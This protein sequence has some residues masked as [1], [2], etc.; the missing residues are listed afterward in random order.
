LTPPILAAAADGAG[1]DAYADRYR[2]L[3]GT[4]RSLGADLQVSVYMGELVAFDPL[5]PP[6]ASALTRLVPAGADRYRVQASGDEVLSNGATVE[7]TSPGPDGR[8][9]RLVVPGLYLDRIR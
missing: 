9:T 7:F 1:P 4:Y 8:P 2:T 5:H 3:T 6:P